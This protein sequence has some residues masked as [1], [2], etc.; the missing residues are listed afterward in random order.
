MACEIHYENGEFQEAVGHYYTT[1]GIALS[2]SNLRTV[3]YT[4]DTHGNVVICETTTNDGTTTRCEYSYDAYGNQTGTPNDGDTNPFRYCGEYYDAESG[5]IYL[6]NRY[7]DPSTGRFITED[8][9]K[10]GVNWY[11]Y[12]NNNPVMFFD[13]FGLAPTKEAAAAMADHI[14]KDFSGLMDSRGRKARTVAGWRLIS[15]LEGQES[16]KMGIYIKDEDDWRNP[17]EYTLVFRGSIIQLNME[18]VDVWKNNVLQAVTGWSQDMKDAI[19]FGKNFVSSHSQE[20]TFVGHSKGGAEAAGAAVATN[21]NAIL[22][23]PANANLYGYGLNGKN[24][25]ANMTQ[26]VVCEEILSKTNILGV[27][28]G[29]VSRFRV[30]TIRTQLLKRQHSALTV[31]GQVNNHLMGAVKSALAKGDFVN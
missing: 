3:T 11:V 13:P 7:Y 20:V 23:N 18:T 29:P 28:L 22:F 9:A 14:Y 16:M 8:P 26:Y 31:W 5:F 6:R 27:Q 30:P 19:A 17:S 10:D 2:K 4:A 12:A 21:K 1:A 25:T 24:Y 15:V